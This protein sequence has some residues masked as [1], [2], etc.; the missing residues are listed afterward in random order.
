MQSTPG[1]SPATFT[2]PVPV[3][4][5][6]LVATLSL[7]GEIV[8]QND[9]WQSVFGTPGRPWSRLSD[10]EQGLVAQFIEESLSGKFV[11][12]EVFLVRIPNWDQPLPVL[13]N[14]LPAQ[15]PDENDV[16][17]LKAVN[18]TGEV[19]TE[20]TTWM[21]N[22]TERH[23][24]ETLGRMT[25]GIAH[26]FNNLLSG[27]LGHTELLKRTSEASLTTAGTEH[28][29]TIE[30][31]ALDGA[32]LVRK[33]QQYIRHER[34]TAFE[35]VDLQKIIEDSI[36][37]TKPYWYNE[38]RRQGISIDT[39]TEFDSV[40]L[41][42]GSSSDLKDVFVNLILNAVQAMPHGG[43]ISFKVGFDENTG[44]VAGV[45]DTGTG[46][47]DRV[48]A[49]I[50]EPLFTT[51]GKRGT[52]MG[53]AVCY[54][55]VQ[56]HDGEIDVETRLGFGTTFWL[57]FPHIESATPQVEEN[58]VPDAGSSARILVVDDEPMVR[59][60]LIKLLTIRGHQVTDASSGAEALAICKTRNFDLVFTDQ[61]MPEMNGRILA[62][63]LR[64]QFPDLPIV[65][66]TGDTEA[67]VAD[68]DINIVLSKP[69]K[70]EALE[71]AI[72]ELV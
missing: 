7:D 72:K 26:D 20:P 10:Q 69:F 5:E 11:T 56:E 21:T 19:L 67:G 36:T 1:N 17:R 43:T 8:Y 2:S 61:G 39:F 15:T 33:I 54:G 60:V 25:M 16:L 58:A 71:A 52:G 18:I 62:G 6:L 45:S 12:A 53:L 4:Q 30:Q 44:V 66:L 27:I 42:N 22:Q 24:M 41:I 49:R 14:F 50:F 40:P 9:A 63:K 34:Q 65:L 57:R 35:P 31:A 37:L 55:T 32:S 51:K 29:E 3:E 13:L 59:S 47:T 70:L 48:R 46:M 23:R 38:P 68:N 28:L 64:A